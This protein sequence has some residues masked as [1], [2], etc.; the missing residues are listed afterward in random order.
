MTTDP[1]TSDLQVTHSPTHLPRVPSPTLP[2]RT[3]VY[4]SPS[5]LPS[6]P[7]DL[8]DTG[9]LGLHYSLSTT[10]DGI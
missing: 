4:P 2:T 10:R 9:S 8:L 5:R 1:S 7:V 6:A 3:K